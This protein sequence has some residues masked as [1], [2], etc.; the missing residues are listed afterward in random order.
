MNLKEYYR[1]EKGFLIVNVSKKTL[2]KYALWTITKFKNDSHHQQ[3]NSSR[4]DLLGGFLD[5]WLNRVPEFLIFRALLDET[6]KKLSDEKKYTLSTIND[7]FFYNQ[8]SAKNAPDI[9][10]LVKQYYNGKKEYYG[11]ATFNNN[12]WDFKEQLNAPFIE[13]K[14]FRKSQKLVTIPKT[15]FNLNHYYAIVSSNIYDD[16]LIYLFDEDIFN[17]NF[18]FESDNKFIVQNNA[19]ILDSPDILIKNFVSDY[20]L[21]LSK[22]DTIGSYKLLGI[23]DGRT[24]EDYSILAKLSKNK[25]EKPRYLSLI[26]EVEDKYVVDV[27]SEIFE[28]YTDSVDCIPLIFD[29]ESHS[30]LSLLYFS[31]ESI[32]VLISGKATLYNFDGSLIDYIEDSCYELKFESSIKN[33]KKYY[34]FDRF[35]KIELKLKNG[36]LD[37]EL[38]SGIFNHYGTNYKNNHFEVSDLIENDFKIHDYNKNTMT[39]SI[40]KDD[41]HVYYKYYFTDKGERE[42]IK[43]GDETKYKFDKLDKCDDKDIL[44]NDLTS[45][46]LLLNIHV[47][48]NSKLKFIKKNK[49]KLTVCIDGTAKIKDNSLDIEPFIITNGFYEFGIYDGTSRKTNPGFDLKKPTHSEQ[50]EYSRL[51]PDENGFHFPDRNNEKLKNSTVNNVK[52]KIDDEEGLIYLVEIGYSR[53][54][55]FETYYKIMVDGRVVIDGQEL[56]DNSNIYKKYWKLKFEKFDRSSKKD[57]YVLSKGSISYDHSLSKEKDLIECFIKFV[58]DENNLLI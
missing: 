57:E 56:V 1:D 58:D 43:T 35:K 3:Q 34:F 48:E 12:Q 39:F 20:K 49:D 16:Y 37:E 23:Y 8:E 26:E 54:H 42:N 45:Y 51:K 24:I 31:E 17:N 29:I 6:N 52:F 47:N 46:K 32:I 18:Q 33:L 10:G 36:I 7:N 11:F 19:K 38:K 13:M 28:Y 15:Q 9:I 5:R 30:K 14:T 53:D 2:I 40:I 50:P 25:P 21:N 41:N 27:E 4:Q 55:D 22:Q 44:K